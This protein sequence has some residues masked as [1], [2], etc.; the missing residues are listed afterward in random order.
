VQ[1]ITSSDTIPLITLADIRRTGGKITVKEPDPKDIFVEPFVEYNNNTGSGDPQNIIAF[2]KVAAPYFDDNYDP[3]SPSNGGYVEDSGGAFSGNTASVYWGRCHDLWEKYGLINEPP[4][5]MTECTWANGYNAEAAKI[6]AY[7]IQK[8]IDWMGN[9]YVSFPVHFTH[10]SNGI[11]TRDWTEGQH[12]NLQLPHETDNAIIE[13]I[14]E[15]IVI[16]PNAPYHIDIE[17]I[18]LDSTDIPE[19]YDILDV[20]FT[21]SEGAGGDWEDTTDEGETQIQDAT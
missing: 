18:L 13:C 20:T 16:D 10:T 11:N 8:W 21:E 17:A 19:D 15:K 4:R 9:R 7:K 1:R 3:D 5:D 2:K 6:A 12:F 14:A